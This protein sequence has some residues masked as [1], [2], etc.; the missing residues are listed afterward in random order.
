MKKDKIYIISFITLLLDQ[1]IKFLITKNMK[2]LE[3]IP[4]IPHFFNIHYIQNR[5]AAWGILQDN[6]I[7]LTLITAVALIILNQYL[8]KEIHF[9][10]LSIISYGLLIGGMLGNLVDRILHS[11]VIDFLDFKIFGYDFPVFNIADIGIVIGIVLLIYDVVRSEINAN[12][13]RKRKC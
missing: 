5:G 1:M 3:S 13:S 9:T 12:R 4:V 11:Y 7:F 6:T 2:V 8:N 10:K